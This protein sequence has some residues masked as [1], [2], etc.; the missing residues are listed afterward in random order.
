MNDQQTILQAILADPSDDLPRLAY[1]DYC[2]EHDDPG[3]AELIRIQ[4]QMHLLSSDHE[5]GQCRA[6]RMGGHH[7]NGPCHCTKEWKKLRGRHLGLLTTENISKW[8]NPMP[9][10]HGG[11]VERNGKQYGWTFKGKPGGQ[12]KVYATFDRGFVSKLICN[13]DD[14][15]TYADS[16]TQQQPIEQVMHLPNA[17][18]M[19]TKYIMPSGA[20]KWYLENRQAEQC[21]VDPMTSE[22]IKVPFYRDN[23]LG[24]VLVHLLYHNWPKIKFL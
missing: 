4:L 2:E 12:P 9:N 10:T 16:I 1:A 19:V 13:G 14:W 18:K 17:P 20:V 23:P 24:R 8:L 11:F 5:C 7:T 15:V 22:S 3:R 6:A 21:G